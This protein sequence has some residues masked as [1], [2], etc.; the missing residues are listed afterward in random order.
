M[1]RTFIITALA[2]FL[3]LQATAQRPVRFNN[4]QSDTARITEVLIELEN[5]GVRDPQALTAMAAK[6]FVGTIYKGG[7][8]EKSPE[9]L[10]IN[11]DSLDCT[12]FVEMATAMALTV[13]DR[14]SSWHD[15]VYNLERIR[16]RGGAIDG[17]PSRLHYVSDWI[18]DNSH[19][20]ITQEVTNR[21]GKADYVVKTIDFMSTH[22]NAYSALKDSANFEK[23]KNMEIGYR[24]HRFPYIKTANLKTAQI[25]EGDIIA[26]TTAT[27]GLDVSHMGIATIID[28]RPHL[29]HA[30]SKAGKVIIDPTDL[31]E[32]L[33]KNRT[34]TG[35]RII[36]LKE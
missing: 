1:K 20:G 25:K 12:T 4:E 36:R 9:M 23:I 16:Y 13:L 27:K 2:A 31:A 22:R 29:V 35:I 33:R 24:S 26:I 14:R 5:S 21:V 15:F 32:Y 3:S 34:S 7:T 18:I 10:T 17:Y 19:R 30:S 11:L 28:G 6:K 8:L